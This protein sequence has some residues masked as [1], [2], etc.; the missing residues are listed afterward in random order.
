M[1]SLSDIT[2]KQMGKVKVAIAKINSV[3]ELRD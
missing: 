1:L 2:Q 3:I